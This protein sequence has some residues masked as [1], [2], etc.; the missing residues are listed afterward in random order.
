M[1]VEA[2]AAGAYRTGPDQMRLRIAEA[3]WAEVARERGIS[4]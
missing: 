4:D 1:R 3:R 2:V